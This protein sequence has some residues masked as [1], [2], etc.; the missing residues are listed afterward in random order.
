[1]G[2]VND[3]RALA[4][5][6]KNEAPGKKSV[7]IAE[8]INV[9]VDG[10]VNFNTPKQIREILSER[11]GLHERTADSRIQAA[12]EQIK[13]DANGA[14]RQEIVATMMSQCL[15]IAKEASETRQL[16]NAIGAMRLYGALIGVVDNGRN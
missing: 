13:R 12:R 4:R 6:A 10:L 16:S 11:Y 14:D 2:S 15:K 9:A 3:R 7:E 1:M 8:Q 5:K